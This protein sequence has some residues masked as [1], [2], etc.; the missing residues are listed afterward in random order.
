MTATER[1]RMKKS[2][3][4]GDPP[5]RTPRLWHVPSAHSAQWQWSSSRSSVQ[6]SRKRGKLCLHCNTSY[7]LHCWAHHSAHTPFWQNCDNHHRGGGETI[8]NMGTSEFQ[9]DNTHCCW[10][11]TILKVLTLTAMIM[12]YAKLM[13]IS[14]NLK[15]IWAKCCMLANQPDQVSLF[16]VTSSSCTGHSSCASAVKF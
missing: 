9:H 5:L 15:H 1:E 6:K 16:L 12:R 3:L 2:C 13:E 7:Y 11:C 4:P 10:S 14:I 8:I